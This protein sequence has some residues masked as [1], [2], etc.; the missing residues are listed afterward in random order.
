M[1]P[2]L[3]GF[4]PE[5]PVLPVLLVF[6]VP[7]LAFVG[8]IPPELLLL[9]LLLEELLLEELLLEPSPPVVPLPPPVSSGP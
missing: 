3:A 4:G 5:L 9:E 1:L 8:V 7:V 2:L 6:V